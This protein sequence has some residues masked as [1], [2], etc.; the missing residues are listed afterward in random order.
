MKNMTEYKEDEYLSLSGIQHFIFCRRQWALI[1][2]EQQW[3]ENLRTVEGKILH[4]KAHDK[5]SSEKRG[6][7]IISRGMAVKSRVLGVSGECDVVE[8]HPNPNGIPLNN[9]VEKY[10]VFPVEYK[11]GE[12]KQ[13]NQDILQLTAQA[14]CLEEMLCCSIDKGYLYYGEIR[15]RI[16]VEFTQK[17]R[18]EVTKTFKEMHEMFNRGYTPKVKISKS[19]NA[20]SLRNICLPVLCKNTSAKAYI[21]KCINGEEL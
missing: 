18:D 1:D 3:S 2:I 17:L 20:C 13:N 19:C 4:Q 6:D 10:S 7:I 16:L 9:S 11:H 5:Y 21:E 14:M 15:H 8:F 12:P